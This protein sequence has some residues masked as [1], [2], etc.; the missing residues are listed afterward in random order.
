MMLRY[1]FAFL[2][3]CCHLGAHETLPEEKS[4]PYSHI[5]TVPS[6]R[7]T[8]TIQGKQ[9]SYNVRAGK[10][11]VP[12]KD[13]TSVGPVS[14]F[15]YFVESDKNRPLAFCFNGGPGSSSIWLHMGV[16]GPKIVQTDD[17]CFPTMPGQYE[18][19]PDSLLSVCDL[20]FIDPVSTGYSYATK[21]E[22]ESPFHE[23]ENDIHSIS[24]FIRLFLTTYNRWSNPKIIIGESYGSAR[25]IGVARLL[26][27][28]YFININALGLVSLALNTGALEF[29][30]PSPTPLVTALPTLALTAH[31]HK[32]LSTS[33]L[34]KSA[35]EIF[36]EASTFA[37]QHYSPALFAGSTLAKD[38]EHEISQRLSELTSI[39]TQEIEQQ[40]LRL[41]PHIFS[42]KFLINQNL[43]FGRFDARV[44]GWKIPLA[45][46]RS[47]LPDP[48]VYT[49]A[50]SFTSSF[51][52]Y[53]LNDLNY[54]ENRPYTVIAKVFENWRWDAANQP[55]EGF[56]YLDFSDDLRHVFYQN[57]N[58]QVMVAAG[59]YDFAIP[60]F[61]QKYSLD[62]L[63]LPK[64]QADNI[65]F[66]TYE[67]GHMMYLH[68]PSRKKFCANLRQL[69]QEACYRKNT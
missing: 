69:V 26:Q 10:C 66:T 9:L 24:N 18:N 44:T 30:H 3:L 20:V 27:E 58:L 35:E 7:Q 60:A 48:S 15:A 22:D 45:F 8:A 65:R 33:M 68:P 28:H 55:S 46:L 12:G 13:E 11:L 52:A 34:E 14:Y 43:R 2:F 67:S 31:Y 49:T 32:A 39:P 61:S 29:H 42:Q 56:G 59:L 62:T 53:L 64:E 25:A 16:L 40:H 47:P 38:K 23:V 37:V 36:D 41:T 63:F 50:S 17:L 54:T 57:P 19:N 4:I 51:H 21:P 5:E 1:F 6:R